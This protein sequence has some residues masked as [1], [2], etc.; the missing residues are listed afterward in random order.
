MATGETR[1]DGV[2]HMPQHYPAQGAIELGYL[3]TSSYHSLVESCAQEPLSVPGTFSLLSAAGHRN[4]NCW[5][6]TGQGRP[7]GCRC[8][9]HIQRFPVLRGRVR[10]FKRIALKH[11]YYHMWNRSS[12]QVQCMKRH[13][14][15]GHWDNQRDGMGREV[16]RGFRMG[17]T[18]IYPWL[19]HIDVWQKPP[20]YC[21]VISL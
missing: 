17:R 1:G 18:H 3:Y 15:P 16:G 4:G 2:E 6:D 20:Q 21:K 11:V 5:E 7:T 9:T 19:I 8:S 10:W 14:K 13:S 12:V